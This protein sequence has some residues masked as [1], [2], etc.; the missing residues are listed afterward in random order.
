MSS[1]TLTAFW[2]EGP[3]PRGPLGY[4]VTAFSLTDAFEIV[5]RAGYQLPDDKSTLRVRAE[6]TPLE[7]EH[8]YVREHMGPIVVRGLWYPFRVVGVGA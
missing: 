4:G 3:D 1:S 7:L 2:I 6:I 5:V 8:P